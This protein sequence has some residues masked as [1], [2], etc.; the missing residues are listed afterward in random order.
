MFKFHC[1]VGGLF[2]SA[3]PAV[4]L[5]LINLFDNSPALCELRKSMM[6]TFNKTFPLI[7]FLKM[8]AVEDTSFSF[9]KLDFAD[10]FCL[11]FFENM[12]TVLLILLTIRRHN[13]VE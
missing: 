2:L 7:P 6:V 4:F 12:L 10:I 1:H 8:R 11:F 3:T 5:P 9:K 13:I